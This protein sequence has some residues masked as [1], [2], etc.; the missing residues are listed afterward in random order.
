[1]S[2]KELPKVTLTIELHA[3]RDLFMA[4]NHTGGCNDFSDADPESFALDVIEH[5]AMELYTL[6]L[7]IRGDTDDMNSEELSLHAWRIS[8][9]LEAGAALVDALH[10]AN[11]KREAAEAKQAASESKAVAS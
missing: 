9:Q 1:M 2:E 6:S 8:R 7:A 4:G 5:A 10:T 11:L 3:L